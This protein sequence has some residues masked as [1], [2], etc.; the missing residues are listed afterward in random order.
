M[1]DLGRRCLFRNRQGRFFVDRTISFVQSYKW[2]IAWETSGSNIGSYYNT[3][4]YFTTVPVA[5]ATSPR[6]ANGPIDK[7][8]AKD[9]ML[10][11]YPAE[12]SGLW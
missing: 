8:A 3:A 12:K 10:P 2:A 11:R 7:R 9:A 1:M 4:A 5:L 6:H